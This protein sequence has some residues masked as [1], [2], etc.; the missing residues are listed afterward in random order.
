MPCLTWCPTHSSGLSAGPE[1][2]GGPGPTSN[3]GDG[4]GNSREED[5]IV[6]SLTTDSDPLPIPTD[7]LVGAY[8]ADKV[9]VYR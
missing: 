7:L 8:G 1:G 2:L 6:P 9:A 5:D 3:G 4:L